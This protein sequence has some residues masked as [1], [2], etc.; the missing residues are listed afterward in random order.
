MDSV[1]GTILVL[2]VLLLSAQAMNLMDVE[3][4]DDAGSDMYITSHSALSSSSFIRSGSGTAQ[5]PYIVSDWNMG[6][7]DI[8]IENTQK[9]ILFRNITFSSDSSFAFYFN[10]ADNIFIENVTSTGRGKFLYSQDCNAMVIDGCNVS[11]IPTSTNVIEFWN[12][13][14]ITLRGNRFANSS[15][16]SSN[17]FF[18]SDGNSQRILDNHFLGIDL[19]DSFF[20]TDGLISN[21]T[22]E[23]ST[24]TL[25]GGDSGSRVKKNIFD[26]PG[27][28]ALVLSNCK[29]MDIVQNTFH[30]SK[31]IEF[32]ASQYLGGDTYGNIYNNTFESCDHGIY[33]STQFN[34]YT[35]RWEVRKNYFGNC[36][37]HAIEWGRGG[38]NRIYENVF[39]HNA[40][41]DNSTTG[42]QCNQQ[43]FGGYYKI[44][45]DHLDS[46][47]FWANHR[48]P[49]ADT[50]GIV[51]A[52]Y[53][54]TSGGT[55][56]FPYTNPY[57]DTDPPHVEITAPLEL[58]PEWSYVTVHWDHGD[59]GSGIEKVEMKV[60]SGSWIDVTG[61][62]FRS[63]F[64][65]KGNHFV[66]IKATDKAG[67][68]NVSTRQYIMEKTVE[69]IDLIS[70]LE[71]QH[72]PRTEVDIEW[73]LASYFTTV[74]QTI[75]IDGNSTYLN[76]LQRVFR[77]DLEEGT[78][79]LVIMCRD[80]GGLTVSR[81]SNFTI[82]L[83]NPVVEIISPQEGSFISSSI[84]NINFNVS[85]NIRLEHLQTRL[86]DGEWIEQSL[87]S[88]LLA[89]LLDK[90]EHTIH[91]RGIDR[92]GRMTT[93]TVNFTLGPT[94]LLRFI[95]PENGTYTRFDQTTLNWTYTG[96]FKWNMAL[97]RVGKAGDFEDIE[98]MKEVIIDLEETGEYE[99]ILRLLDEF[100]NYIET[101]LNLIKDPVKP[102]GGFVFPANGAYL[103]TKDVHLSWQGWDNN[104]FPI[105][106]YLVQI[107][108]GEWM[109][110]GLSD[111]NN[112]TLFEGAHTAGVR[113]FDMAGNMREERISFIVDLT[114]PD[115][116]FTSP[117]NG[118]ILTDSIV[119]L[120]FMALDENGLQRLD[121]SVDDE[122]NFSVIGL[123]S[124]AITIGTDGYH[125]V[126]LI[127]EDKAGN[128]AV[129]EIELIVDLLEP[130]VIWNEEPIGFTSSENYTFSWNITEEI[131]ISS[132]YVTIDGAIVNLDPGDR[133]ATIPLD[134]GIHV[135][136][137]SVIDL[138]GW[139]SELS[140]SG[141][142]IVDFTPPIVQLDNFNS[143]VEGNTANILWS[144]AD[145]G[146]GIGHAEI[147]LDDGP[148]ERVL[149]EKSDEFT[150]EGLSTGEHRALIRVFD[151]AGNYKEVEWTFNVDLGEGEDE[152]PEDEFDPLPVIL[153]ALGVFV[154]FFI[155]II[156]IVLRKKRKEE[157]KRL[158]SR[159][160]K[161]KKPGKIALGSASVQTSRPLP[162][163]AK[164]VQDLPPSP[165][166]SAKVEETKT[167]SGYIRPEKKKKPK[168]SKR[169][170]EK[171]SEDQIPDF[172]V[173]QDM[174][175]QEDFPQED[176]PDPVEQPMMEKPIFDG[177][178][179]NEDDQTGKE[180]DI[181]L[182]TPPEKKVIEPLW[183]EDIEHEDDEGR[184]YGFSGEEIDWSGKKM[185]SIDD[186]KEEF[187]MLEDEEELEEIDEMEDLEEIE[188]FDE[189][190]LDEFDPE[191][192]DDEL[193]EWG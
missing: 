148:F 57:F 10:D 159:K 127:A 26:T 64:L 172:M 180:E 151:R 119:D 144:N 129:F 62:S 38:A 70:P 193:E 186:Q 154:L 100:D 98:G 24:V 97:L 190:D 94:P 36:S 175:Q 37:T 85:D 165:P 11:S 163:E 155:V 111:N 90:G 153:G 108:S 86:D 34:V 69:V 138:A 2:V 167:G 21:N 185:E 25:Y 142:L 134:E 189:D 87:S 110:M 71:D 162:P 113:I 75:M 41:T 143:G 150:F 35:S 22:F 130:F 56:R 60:D 78:H 68:T 115:I 133:N 80:Q 187:E 104:G 19:S 1:R 184:D 73:K 135:I 125:S 149:A 43:N 12:G 178:K 179:W 45:W 9:H 13:I 139:R 50:N 182:E 58:Y 96:P 147:S 83:T 66:S 112:F 8:R 101:S 174:E 132:I 141:E 48:I 99:I 136:S 67:F 89:P 126:K 47:N 65:K 106:K 103:G 55:D 107:N 160:K 39:Y 114:L 177:A 157:E 192:E 51:D 17:I 14:D 54:I 79:D 16:A 15:S 91:V 40:G 176:I 171:P 74:N 6:S 28:S 102:N 158:E 161:M 20:G 168:K 53:S 30:A 166:P 3:A 137:I 122:G 46:G 128:I 31:G 72:I 59:I 140:A 81:T 152:E 27:G 23:D 124:R 92:S 105:A 29:Y 42:S 146:S 5:A 82:D 7:Y 123:S 84:V 117:Q 109:D 118:S 52:P 164:Q 188:D 121:I 191:G 44:L 77:P 116:G 32:I 169:V 181:P 173:G 49:D 145:D 88:K 93:R 61:K 4:L 18:H 95:S 183:D 156:G 33:S 170:I 76:P 63:I 131:G 120:E